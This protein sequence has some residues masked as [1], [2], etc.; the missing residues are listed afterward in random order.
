MRG[1]APARPS[2]RGRRLRG[3]HAVQ[4]SSN[5]RFLSPPVTGASGRHRSRKQACSMVLHHLL[6]LLVQVAYEDAALWRESRQATCTNKLSE[7]VMMEA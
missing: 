1:L 3:P 6:N 4:F 5:D 7:C 2:L